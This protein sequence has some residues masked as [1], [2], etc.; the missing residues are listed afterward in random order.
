[1]SADLELLASETLVVATRT[2]DRMLTHNAFGLLIGVSVADIVT[3]PTYLPKIQALGAGG[4]WQDYWTAAAAIAANSDNLYLITAVATA[5]D[6][7]GIEVA[8]L[9]PPFAW[10]LV[11]TFGSTGSAT[12]QADAQILGS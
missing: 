3:T 2:S 11:L 6:F 10:R 5:A 9:P 7:D 12:I 4:V 1:M 8:Q